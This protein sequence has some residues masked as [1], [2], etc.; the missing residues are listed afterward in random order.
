MSP[1]PCD[2]SSPR[3]RPRQSPTAPAN[4]SHETFAAC[5]QVALSTNPRDRPAE[6]AHHQPPE[7]LPQRDPKQAP[8]KQQPRSALRIPL[9]EE[10]GPSA[11]PETGRTN[12]RDRVAPASTADTSP[13]EFELGRPRAGT[14]R[15]YTVLPSTGRQTRA[16]ERAAI[17]RLNSPARAGAPRCT[18]PLPSSMANSLRQPRATGPRRRCSR[19]LPSPS[20]PRVR[21]R[22]PVP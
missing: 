17:L 3:R 4:V 21:R 15:N 5:P 8:A 22:T 12:G 19:Q 14:L 6:P 1:V 13:R 7:F 11:H 20:E 2:R 9:T 16:E 10:S 18:A